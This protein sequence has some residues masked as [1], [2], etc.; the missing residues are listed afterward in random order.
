[1]PRQKLQRFRELPQF[2]NISQTTDVDLKSKLKKF[3]GA[4]SNVVLELACGKG[5]YALG[6]A[7][8]YPNNKYIG[9]D[10]QGERLWFA[11]TNAKNK[12]LNNVFFLR[13]PIEDLNKYFKPKS[14]HEIWLTFPDPFPRLKQAK[15]RLTSPKFLLIYK[16]ILKTGGVLHLKTDD[17]DLFD[18]S[19]NTIEN[20][21]GKTIGQIVDI[22]KNKN[23]SPQL[24]IKTYYENQHLKAGKKIYY[25]SFKL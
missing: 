22:Y 25:L 9:I 24:S 21:G 5:E 20:S 16:K 11:C 17:K 10:I 23:L 12:K 2:D 6:L 19:I 8:L 14:V 18:Y 4:K 3:L 15:K 7:E 13:I 1:M